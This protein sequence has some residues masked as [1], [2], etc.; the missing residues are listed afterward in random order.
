MCADSVRA[1]NGE[2]SCTKTAQDAVSVDL[3][4]HRSSIYH[5]GTIFIN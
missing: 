5:G 1:V 4:S 3:E 2:R